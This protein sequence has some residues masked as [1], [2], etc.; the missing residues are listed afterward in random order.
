MNLPVN[1]MLCFWSEMRIHRRHDKPRYGMKQNR[2]A[3]AVLITVPLLLL[4]TFSAQSETEQSG[5]EAG[6]TAMEKSTAEDAVDSEDKAEATGLDIVMDGSSLEAFEKSMEQVKETGTAEE[7]RALESAI[8]YLLIYDLSAKR[9][10][11]KLIERLNGRTG[12]E[13]IKRVG[14]GKSR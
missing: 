12:H 8:D 2:L 1:F 5:N 4:A 13:I 3:I 14:W 11:E 7:Y 9:N 6:A 10:M